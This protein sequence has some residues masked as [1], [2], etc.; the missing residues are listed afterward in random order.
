MVQGREAKKDSRWTYWRGRGS[1]DGMETPSFGT[2]ARSWRKACGLTQADAAHRLGVA[3]PTVSK[4]ERDERLPTTRILAAMGE[5]YALDDVTLASA[6][7]LAC[8]E[9]AVTDG[10]GDDADG[11]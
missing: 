5:L 2:I 6:L 1:L 9:M 10:E 4:I 11:P 8:A 7:R 3:Q